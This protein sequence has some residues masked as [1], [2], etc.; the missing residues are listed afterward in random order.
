MVQQ[1]ADQH[2]GR[3]I[4]IPSEGSVAA[5][6]AAGLC[7]HGWIQRQQPASLHQACP[8]A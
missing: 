5:Q 8:N 4:L 2:T 1:R 3:L 7:F 6:A